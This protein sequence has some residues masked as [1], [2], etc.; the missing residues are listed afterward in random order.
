MTS[1]REKKFKKVDFESNQ[2]KTKK[3][4]KFPSMQRVNLPINWCFLT[5][6]IYQEFFYISVN[7]S[8]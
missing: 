5:S 7:H 1:I 8:I 4:A 2:Q 6:S 3:H